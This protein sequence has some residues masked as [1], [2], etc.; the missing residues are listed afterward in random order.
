MPNV[1]R[2]A[3]RFNSRFLIKSFILIIVIS[4][5]VFASSPANKK[6]SSALIGR[7]VPKNSM[8]IS[9]SPWGIQVGTLE[10]NDLKKAF[11]IGVKWTRLN[12]SWK[13]I[14]RREGKYS[15]EE[16]DKA[17]NAALKN[18]ITPFVCLTGSNPIY[19]K[20]TP[21]IES[22]DK[23]I[24]GSSILPPIKDSKAMAAW[25]K[26]VKATVL[27]YKDKVHYWEIWNEPNHPH[28]WGAPVDGVEY[29]KLVLETAKVIKGN[30]PSAKIIAGALAGI[31]PSFTDQ[32]LSA[33]SADYIDIITF[34]NYAELPED[35]IYLAADEWNI[36][37]KYKPSIELWQG[38]CG[39]P[40]HSNTRDYR[41]I[42]PW[43]LNIQAKW[44]LRQSFTDIFFC[45]AK[46]SNYFKLVHSGGRGEMPVRNSLTSLDSVLGFKTK[47]GSRVKSVGVNEKCLLENP[48]Y[49]PKPAYFA[50]QNLCSVFDDRYQITKIE[51]KIDVNNE[52]LFYGI[53][54][55]DD[56]FPSIPLIASFK[57]K[58]EK[59][60]L[61]YWL[62][63]HPQEIIK[64]AT[65]VLNVGKIK[66]F[67]PVL[68]DL[69]SGEVYKLEVEQDSSG[70]SLFQ[71]IPL[72]DYPF[73]IAE[74][75]EVST[76][77]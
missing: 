54:K 72:A 77:S 36:I 63:W 7:L 24:Y 68:V 64:E 55:E 71:N 57:T 44:L 2:T 41:G 62:P 40:S 14:E 25:L 42:S 16:N 73:I 61:A 17:F 13:E 33:G 21:T 27:R 3:D 65:I 69:L 38:E 15:W 43:G 50:Y 52:G 1:K 8:Q 31:D 66:F 60:L 70:N 59:Y 74:K 32:F 51:S 53:G 5:L 26:F 75:S 11:G 37:N 6:D 34:H 29:G 30:D 23:E 10:E 20:N 67:D 28:Y 48:T 56:A 19:C 47:G 18:G 46:L 12:A 58:N 22:L 76:G 4:F 9:K 39:Y 35:R 45:R 49:N